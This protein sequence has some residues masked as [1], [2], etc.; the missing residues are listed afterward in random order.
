MKRDILSVLDMKEDFE[1]L[2][3]LSLKLKRSRY[4]EVS[5]AK[6]R[7]LA[8]IFEKPSTRT[9]VSFESA[10]RQIGGHSLYLNP[11]D[12]QLGRGETISD[13]AK[14]LSRMVDVIAYRAF[15]HT[16]MM[17]LARNA[18]IPVINALDD[19][20]HPVQMLADFMTLYEKFGNL[21]GLNLTYA[22]D[23]NN[24]ANS[25]LYASA[26]TGVNIRVATPEGYEPKKEYVSKATELASRYG[27][28][29][30]ILNDPLKAA[31]GADAVYTD[32]WISMGEENQRQEKE[33]LFIK[34]QVNEKLMAQ[35]SDRAVFLHCLPAHRNLEVTPGVIDGVRSVVFDEAE[36]RLHTEKALLVRLLS[37]Q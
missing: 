21:K 19:S 6:N 25:L 10:M 34:Y 36:N 30:E 8:M 27:S 4:E 35:A 33:K 18:T 24:V 28:S 31:K 15:E 29:V 2:I 13:T 1:D 9:R 26:L 12:M 11:N 7:V 14:V 5:S 37:L 22:G 32:V 16:K 3:G 20:E 23:G 17:E